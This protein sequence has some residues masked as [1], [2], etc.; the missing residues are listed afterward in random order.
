MSAPFTDK[1]GRP[2]AEAKRRLAKMEEMI[3]DVRRGHYDNTGMPC[4]ISLMGHDCCY[5]CNQV[6]A[7]LLAAAADW[8]DEA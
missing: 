2:N 7:M 4:R 3:R 5:T 8:D 6:E 1:R